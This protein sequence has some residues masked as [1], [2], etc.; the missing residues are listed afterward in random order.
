MRQ[1]SV[2]AAWGV[3]SAIL[4]GLTAACGGTGSSKPTLQ[5]W[6]SDAGEEDDGPANGTCGK[7]G[8]PDCPLQK[9]MKENMKPALADEDKARLAKAYETLA[10]HPPAG[11][12]GW[13]TIARKGADAAQQ[14][15][16]S[17]AKAQCKACHD[18]LR[19]RFKKELRDKPL[20]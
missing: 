3:S 17:T 14:G 9:W 18:D 19:S 6:S 11:F 7:K 5:E 2:F 10:A 1:W 16:F 12:T 13:D 8:L 15:D 4:A 20:F